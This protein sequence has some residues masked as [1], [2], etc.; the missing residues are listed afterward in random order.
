MKSGLDDELA[1]Q[2]YI[3]GSVAGL[4]N[5]PSCATSKLSRPSSCSA[6]EFNRVNTDT[7]DNLPETLSIQDVKDLL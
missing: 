5:L 2:Y 7:G 4:Y 3:T 1:E 6:Q